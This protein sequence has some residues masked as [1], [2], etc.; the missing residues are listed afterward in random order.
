MILAQLPDTLY[1]KGVYDEVRKLDPDTNQSRLKFIELFLKISNTFLAMIP[2][3]A[4]GLIKIFE[5]IKLQLT[6]NK[7]ESRVRIIFLIGLFHFFFVVLG[8]RRCQKNT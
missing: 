3:S 8:I 6:K 7:L 2:Y 5:H 1:L 4:D